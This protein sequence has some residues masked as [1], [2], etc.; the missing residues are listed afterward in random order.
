M[1]FK[2]IFISSICIIITDYILKLLLLL[3]YDYDYDNDHDHDHHYYYHY[4]IVVEVTV[5][6]DFYFVT[7]FEKGIGTLRWWFCVLDPSDVLRK[8]FGVEWEPCLLVKLLQR[9]CWA[10]VRFQTSLWRITSGG[11]ELRN[12]S[13]LSNFFWMTYWSYWHCMLDSIL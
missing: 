1:S 9:D 6:F 5:C 3:N 11:T 8:M 2:P 13:R 10:G 4:Y 7:S 12:Y